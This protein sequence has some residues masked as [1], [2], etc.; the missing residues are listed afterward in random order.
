[1]PNDLTK[2][3]KWAQQEIDRLQRN[4]EHWKAK[5]TAGPDTSDTWIE[6]HAG[7]TPLGTNVHV[8]FTLPGGHELMA[9]REGHELRVSGDGHNAI[10]VVPQASNVVK[11]RPAAWIAGEPLR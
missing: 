5:A 1:M 3:P 6:H 10:A 8:V 4:V 2:L 9:Y 7:R 11:V